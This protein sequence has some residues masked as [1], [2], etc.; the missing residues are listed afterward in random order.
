MSKKIKKSPIFYMGNKERL[1][2]KGL[3]DLFPKNIDNFIDLFCGSGII[4][5]NINARRYILNDYNSI[6][7]DLLNLFKNNSAENIIRKME[8]TIKSHN[9][10]KGFYPQQKNIKNW[11]RIIIINLE[12]IIT[13]LIIL[14]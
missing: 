7:I 11:L 2:K 1:I 6:I 4:S 9:L 13:M 5:M 14:F 12:I 10:L 8:E 3:I